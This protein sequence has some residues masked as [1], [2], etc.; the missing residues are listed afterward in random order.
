[1]ARPK[2]KPGYDREVEI[3]DLIA[4]A[5]ALFDVPYDDRINKQ[6]RSVKPSTKIRAIY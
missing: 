3:A 6:S 5:A 1:M 2:K 4:T